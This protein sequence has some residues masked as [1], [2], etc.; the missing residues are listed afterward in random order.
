MLNELFKRLEAETPKWFKGII[1]IGLS[2]AA[3]GVAIK[4]TVGTMDDFTLSAFGR[5]ITNYMI[6]AGDVAA[7]V[8]QTAKKDNNAPTP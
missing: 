4:L 2:L 6:L 8:S 3:A 7:A 1:N 5:T